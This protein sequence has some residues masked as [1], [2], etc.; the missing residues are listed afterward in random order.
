MTR[1]KAFLTWMLLLSSA[2]PLLALPRDAAAVLNRCGKPLRGDEEVLDNSVAGGHRQL[3][4]ERGILHFD[5]VAMDGWTFVYGTH[6]KQD[7]L[8]ADQMAKFMPCLTDALADSAAPEPLR[9]ITAVER[10]ETSMKRS[11]LQLVIWAFALIC[12]SGLV[13]LLP[14]MRKR[15]EPVDEM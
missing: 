6:R 2:S 3:R 10:V 8:P 5:K 4:Y 9:H 1:N 13:L 12:L 11:Y 15:Q 7:H 14:G